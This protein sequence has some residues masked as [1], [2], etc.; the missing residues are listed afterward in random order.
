MTP[1]QMHWYLRE[2]CNLEWCAYC[3]GV[4]SE[5]S[6][7]PERDVELAKSLVAGKVKKTVL[8]GGEPTL[9]GN[10]DEVLRILKDGG[11]YTSLHTNGL[12]LSDKRLEQLHGL[13]D[14]IALPIDTTDQEVQMQL[15]GQRFAP[16]FKR[17]ETLAG[18]INDYG[19]KLGW[20]TVF[21]AINEQ[22]IPQ[23]YD[24]IKQHDFD[25]LRIYEY[26]D[27]LARQAW[28]TM[29]GVSDETKVNGFLR[30]QALEKPGTIEKG[31]T[32]S[33]LADFLRMEEQMKAAGD[34][35]VCFV[36]R[37]DETKAPYAF[38]RNTGEVDYYT[39]CSFNKRRKLG[40]LFKDGMAKI[41]RKWRTLRDG[42]DLGQE[43]EDW[44]ESTSA[45]PLWAR[46][47]EGNYWTEEVED[48]LPEYL[49]E[50]E[51]LANLW[52]ARNGEKAEVSL[53]D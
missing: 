13:V 26:N 1:E 4:R 35:R 32:D 12:L 38:L 43:I 39:W 6:A 33:L 44:L 45:L 24:F 14:E 40:N 5:I 18:K 10:L 22:G 49:P 3:F 17:L 31:G 53:A 41:D 11:V 19:I 15:R 8:G 28:I 27:E 2:E 23:V 48:V 37:L 51:R 7:T 25:Y 36:A 16:V 20:H 9:A 21:T 50:V 29:K 30:A 52:L 47:Y 46:L 42:G 34:P